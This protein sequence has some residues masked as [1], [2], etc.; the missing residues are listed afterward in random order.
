MNK[1]ENIKVIAF[2]TDDTLWV[3]EPIFTHTQTQFKTLLSRYIST[4]DLDEKLYQTESKNLRLF[5]YGVK[6]FILSMIE[7][8]IE[9]TAGKVSGTDI[10]TI[11]D[12]GKTM[13]EHPV[14]L[15]DGVWETVE[16]LSEQ[17]QLM[18]ITKGD[19]FHQESKIA[20]SGLADYFQHIEIVSEKNKATYQSILDRYEINPAEFLMVGNSLRS[21]ILPICECQAQAIHIPFHTTWQHETVEH[22]QLNGFE[23]DEIDN[24][25][26]LPALLGQL[27]PGISPKEVIDCGHFRLRPLQKSD[28]TSFSE[29]ANN[30][31]IAGMVQD[32]FPHP[33]FQKD[34]EKFIDFVSK[35]DEQKVFGIDI[36][37]KAVGAVGLRMQPDV[38]RISAEMGYWLGEPYWGRGIMSRAIET[39]ANHAFQSMGLQRVFARVYHINPGSM[40]ALE[41]A[42]FKKEGIARAAVI[43]NREILDI[44]LYGKVKGD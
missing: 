6:G 2:D 39:V 43:K 10:Q 16:K 5:G 17:Y 38:Y 27:K 42:G 8:A 3:N 34:A 1:F 13:L 18:V 36:D 31:K 29:N 22:H 25:R 44:H 30:A 14:E 9:L 33:Y 32:G 23:Y 21:D 19:L 4:V 20:S 24:L 40:K 12:F 7:T 11:I 28:A 35:T 37:G 15:L 41:K 26:Q